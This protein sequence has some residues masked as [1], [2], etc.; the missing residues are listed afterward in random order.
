MA[1]TYQGPAVVLINGSEYPAVVDLEISVERNDYTVVRKSWD[2]T[3]DSD[4][5]IGW[6]TSPTD[7]T[8]TLR[9]PDGREGRFIATAGSLGSG[10]VEISGTGPA[11]FGD[12]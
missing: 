11:P 9:M 7:G 10:L 1:N 12:A 5:S 4:P 8:A 6:F 2:G 3:I